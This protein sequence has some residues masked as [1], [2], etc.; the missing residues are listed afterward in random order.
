MDFLESLYFAVCDLI[1]QYF[2]GEA[3]ELGKGMSLNFSIES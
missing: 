3:D 1:G 2:Y